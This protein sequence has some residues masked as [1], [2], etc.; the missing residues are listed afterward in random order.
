M[1]AFCEITTVTF[2]LFQISTGVVIVSLS[3]ETE[4]FVVQGVP[5]TV[6]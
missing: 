2:A 6:T 3:E 5:L 1:F 4:M